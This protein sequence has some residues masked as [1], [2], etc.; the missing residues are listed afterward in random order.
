MDA[1]IIAEIIT[2]KEWKQRIKVWR[3]DTTMSP[4]RRHC[5]YY[6]MLIRP[7]SEI[8]NTEKGKLLSE[9]QDNITQAYV[10]LT[11]YTVEYEYSYKI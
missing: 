6:K 4:S 1:P 7:R 5:G 3:E 8:T 10:D 2:K 11:K 9:K